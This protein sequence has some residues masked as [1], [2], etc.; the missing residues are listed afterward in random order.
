MV[1][2]VSEHRG[3]EAVVP[4]ADDG[5]ADP[6]RPRLPRLSVR[7]PGSRDPRPAEVSP[8]SPCS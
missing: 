5:P 7:R 2:G 8:T 3:E 1:A 4:R 6:G